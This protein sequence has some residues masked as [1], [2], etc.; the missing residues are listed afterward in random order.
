VLVILT[1]KL[2]LKD[3]GEEINEMFRWISE[4]PEIGHLRK[5]QGNALLNQSGILSEGHAALK[6][7][8]L[9]RHKISNLHLGVLVSMR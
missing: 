8:P 2:I 4:V 3:L 5:M 9:G 6:E 7:H 1:L